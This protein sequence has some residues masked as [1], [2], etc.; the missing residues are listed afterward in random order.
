MRPTMEDLDALM[1]DLDISNEENEELVFDEEFEEESNRFELCLVGRLLTEKNLNVRAMKSKL[2][3][4]WRP[5]MGI[6]IKVLKPGVFLFQFYH[7]DDLKWMLTN[8]PWSFE[9]AMLIV[10]SIKVGEDP[11]MVTLNE[12]EIWIQIYNLPVGFMTEKVGQ[13][14]GNFFGRFI[15]YDPSNNASIWR[16]YMR[17]RIAVD[18]R[19]PLKRKKKIIRQNK[20]EIMVTCKYEKLAD[21]CFLCG[22]LTHTERFCKRKFEGESELMAREWGTWLRAPA[23][24]GGGQERSKWLREEREDGWSGNFGGDRNQ[25]SQPTDFVRDRII[26]RDSRGVTREKAP[27]LENSN[28]TTDCMEEG[29]LDQAL[30]NGPVDSELDGLE[31]EERKRKRIGPVLTKEN[32]QQ[33]TKYN[34]EPE[35]SIADCSGA[36]NTFLAQLAKQASRS[37]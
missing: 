9:G 14:L 13:Q 28:N 5:A 22:L 36:S 23:R 16:E 30:S 1:T 35:L 11:L 31:M 7:K 6:T 4:L 33:G 34:Q 29:N 27:I 8:G 32:A 20:A 18:I 2:A 37:S 25:G 26:L 3:D 12:M 10:N 21:F 15:S 17:V 19:Y 24:R